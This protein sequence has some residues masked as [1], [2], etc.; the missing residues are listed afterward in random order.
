MGLSVGSDVAEEATD[1]LDHLT[2][3]GAQ[4]EPWRRLRRSRV[5]KHGKPSVAVAAEA[6]SGGVVD[7]FFR[8]ELED[9]SLPLTEHEKDASFEASGAEVDGLPVVVANDYTHFS[10]WIVDLDDTLHGTEV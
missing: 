9:H 10:G 7:A 2:G 6:E 4:I 5:P 8:L 1:L 3:I